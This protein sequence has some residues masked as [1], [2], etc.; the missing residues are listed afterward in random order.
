MSV[1]RRVARRLAAESSNPIPAVMVPARRRCEVCGG[2]VIPG[3]ERCER[4]ADQLSLFSA[5]VD[6]RRK[7]WRS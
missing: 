5:K 1:I 6:R 4:C 3:D 2:R 7:E